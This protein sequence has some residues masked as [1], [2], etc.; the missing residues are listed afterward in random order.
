MAERVDFPVDLDDTS[1]DSGAGVPDDDD[2]CF[3]TQTVDEAQGTDIYGNSTGRPGDDDA[4]GGSPDDPTARVKNFPPTNVADT[5]NPPTD[6]ANTAVIPTQDNTSNDK[7][8]NPYP[9]RSIAHQWIMNH[10][11]V[12]AHLS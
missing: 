11:V 7:K 10:K 2:S 6:N 1:M 9:G 3:S 8:K 5:T 4:S 12:F